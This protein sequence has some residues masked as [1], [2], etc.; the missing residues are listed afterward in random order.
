QVARIRGEEFAVFLPGAGREQAKRW[1]ERFESVVVEHNKWVRNRLPQISVTTGAAVY[2]LDGARASQLFEAADRRLLEAKSKLVRPPHEVSVSTIAGADKLL[3][4][5]AAEPERRFGGFVGAT[6]LL[7]VRWTFAAAVFGAYA[8]S[9]GEA[10]RYPLALASVAFYCLALGVAGFAMRG[11]R[12]DRTLAAVS[13][14]S[15]ILLIVPVFW[16]SGGWQSPLQLVVMFP[17]VYYA[18]FLRGR[19]ATSRVA[20]VISMYTFAYWTSGPLGFAET[21]VSPAGQTIYA[22]IL[23]ALLVLTVIVQSSRRVTDDA[24]RRIK[25]SATR[26]PL[27]GL[28]NIHA[29]REDLQAMIAAASYRPAGTDRPAPAGVAGLRSLPA[30]TIADIDDFRGINNRSGHQAGDAVLVAVAERRGKAVGDMATAYHVECDEFAVLY[31]VDDRQQA[32]ELTS[33]VGGA[34]TRNPDLPPRLA[35]PIRFSFGTA[36]WQPGST[37]ATLV[38]DAAH[39]LTK[40]RSANGVETSRGGAVLL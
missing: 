29:F 36:I 4:P 37:A 40:M 19:R 34:V 31:K 20:A 13:D 23:A 9:S 33:A 8:L 24:F 35:E 7:G 11:T 17:V 32:D 14:A 39:E 27:T 5:A 22:T 26:D 25:A 3:R 16:T 12:H 6:Q 1:C 18:Q 15:S 30:L 38:D 10:L 28:K 2:P 21:P